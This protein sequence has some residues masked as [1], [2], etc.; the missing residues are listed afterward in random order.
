MTP[1]VRA[2]AHQRGLFSMSP[3]CSQW[4]FTAVAGATNEAAVAPCCLQEMFRQG[5]TERGLG[6]PVSP[7]MDRTKGGITKAQS[8]FFNVVALPMFSAL[9][10]VFP[11]TNELLDS[12][13][14][15]LDMWRNLEEEAKA[16]DAL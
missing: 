5:D 16:G 7:L 10:Q 2:A 12:L 9:A 1:C 13:K 11:A 6:Q 8:G 15:N 14:E 3:G 4:C